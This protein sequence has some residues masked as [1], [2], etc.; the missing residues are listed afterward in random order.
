M[1]RSNCQSF[2]YQ[3][4]LRCES[5]E[6]FLSNIL[7]YIVRTY[8]A[9]FMVYSH[10]QCESVRLTSSLLDYFMCNVCTYVYIYMYMCM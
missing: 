4:W 5:A 6:V 2:V 1:L 10:A 3:N 7:C 8:I 9:Y